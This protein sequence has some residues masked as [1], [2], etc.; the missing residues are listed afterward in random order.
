MDRNLQIAT[1]A[2]LVILILGV[3]WIAI[4]VRP[5]AALADSP[6]L[7]AVGSIGG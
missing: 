4:Q 3:T 7:R 5:I 2:L 6:A 1:V